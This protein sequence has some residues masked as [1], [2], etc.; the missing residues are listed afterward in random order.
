MGSD[1][2]SDDDDAIEAEMQ[3][4][5]KK[6]SDKEHKRLMRKLQIIAKADGVNIDSNIGIRHE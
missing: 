3:E 1:P 4:L 2:I 5:I 6:H